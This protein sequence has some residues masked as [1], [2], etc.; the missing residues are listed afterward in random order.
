MKAEDIDRKEFLDDLEEEEDQGI[1]M[2]SI[3]TI[4]KNMSDEDESEK[5]E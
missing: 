4:V 2:I 3:A 5:F 1:S